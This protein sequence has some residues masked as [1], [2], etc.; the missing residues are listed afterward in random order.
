MVLHN[1]YVKAALTILGRVDLY[2]KMQLSGDPRR[3]RSVR[4]YALSL[5]RQAPQ[6][7]RA[8]AIHMALNS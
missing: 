8:A 4:R 1:D 3:Y 2:H 7:V 6:Y 5:I